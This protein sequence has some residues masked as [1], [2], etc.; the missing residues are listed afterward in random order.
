V[1]I[2]VVAGETWPR[3]S[4]TLR[5]L[6]Q[7][8]QERDGLILDYFLGTA[9]WHSAVSGMLDAMQALIHQGNIDW[10][11]Y[12]L[13]DVGFYDCTMGRC[14]NGHEHKVDD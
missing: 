4:C 7:Q 1:L 2:C 10:N 5:P 3:I 6:G 13:V 14:H 11:T 9:P 8:M 12:V